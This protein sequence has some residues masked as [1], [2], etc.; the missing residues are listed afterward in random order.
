MDSVPPMSQFATDAATLVTDAVAAFDAAT[1]AEALEA[2][3][4][5]FLGDRSGRLRA[6]QR[7]LGALPREDR[8][9]AGRIFN[10]TKTHLEGLYEQRASQ[11]GVVGRGGLRVSIGMSGSGSLAS[12]SRSAPRWKPSGTTSGPSTFPKTT[13]R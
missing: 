1:S 3:R 12:R 13:P 8:P 10:E 9:Q 6:L 5:Q 4:I 7:A 2:A 11:V